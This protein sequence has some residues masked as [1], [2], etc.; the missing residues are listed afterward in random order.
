VKMLRLGGIACLVAPNFPAIMLVDMGPG[1]AVWLNVV[2]GESDNEIMLPKDIT[3]DQAIKL[4][5]ES[6]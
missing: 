4:V 2:G 5:E 3:F 1:D 6:A